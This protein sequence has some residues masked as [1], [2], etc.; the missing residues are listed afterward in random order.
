MTIKLTITDNFN[1][2]TVLVDA[3]KTPAEVLREEEIDMTR[4]MWN[5][6]GVTL[7]GA[8][9]EQPFEALNPNERLYLSR[10]AKTDNAR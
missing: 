7:T 9:M 1:A 2:K 10:V 8:E 3:T 5:L 4:G 6:Q